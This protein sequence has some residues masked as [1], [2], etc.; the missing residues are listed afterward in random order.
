MARDSSHLADY[1]N[2]EFIPRWTSVDPVEDSSGKWLFAVTNLR[3]QAWSLNNPALPN[4]VADL[5]FSQT[6]MEAIIDA[7]SATVFTTIRTAPNSSNQI[8]V[9][10]VSLAGVGVFNTTNKMLPA[11]RYQD[12]NK[13]VNELYTARLGA[14]RDYLFA[15]G[16]LNTAGVRVYD[17][18]SIAALGSTCFETTPSSILCGSVHV[19]AIGPASLQRA[20]GIHG[21]GNY[22][23]I[24]APM[25]QAQGGIYIYNVSTPSTPLQVMSGL[26]GTGVNDVAMWQQGSN[27][28]LAVRTFNQA[29]I[30]DVSCIGTGS[31]ALGQPIWS[32][33]MPGSTL[34]RVSFSRSGAIPMLYWATGMSCGN[35]TTGEILQEVTNPAAPRTI[36]NPSYWQ[37]YHWDTN[38]G[39]NYFAPFE[40][41]FLND[42]F[43]RAAFSVLDVHRWNS[44]APPPPATIGS[45]SASPNP[46]SVCQPITFTANNV[47]NG[48]GATYNWQV[49]T[50]ADAPVTSTTSGINL[51]PFAWNTTGATPGTY[52]GK[53]VINNAGGSSAPAFSALVTVNGLT[54]LAGTGTF[55]PVKVVDNSGAV[56]FDVNAAGATEWSWDFGDSGGAFGPWS[57]DPI[58]GKSPTHVYSS[59]G[60]KTVRVQVRNC[61]QGPA[62]STSL[63]IDVPVVNPLV[64]SFAFQS[65][66]FQLP[67]PTCQVGSGL[68]FADSSTGAQVWDYDW[69][70]KLG[71][72]GCDSFED[73]GHA[74]PVNNH[75]YGTSGTYTPQLRVKRGTSEHVFTHSAIDD[76]RVGAAAA[77]RRLHRRR[78]HAATGSAPFPASRL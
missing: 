47:T 62:T 22:L 3:V 57:N 39:F 11:L 6:G 4:A 30:Y 16:A 48:S 41:R 23:A 21:A 63:V 61:A 10:G 51:N 2:P 37:Y 26:Q 50:A 9:G 75:T 70:C 1:G 20:S 72:A 43:Y 54:P 18:T 64:A 13:D 69:D 35:G 49:L 78:P 76:P 27:Y 71:G 73:S 19:G 14:N 25:F 66:A 40:G 12:R 60:S 58:N 52:K 5:G 42:Y 24:A 32:M 77:A 36:G 33:T 44:G 55:S 17:L 68:N 29:R 67:G 38:T 46:A 65:C 15:A 31:C 74:T 8:A 59:T 45:I 7:H 28:Y 34:A 56:K 53:L